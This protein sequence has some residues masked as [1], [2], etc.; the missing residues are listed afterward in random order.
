MLLDCSQILGRSMKLGANNGFCEIG[1]Q[2]MQ[3]TGKPIIGEG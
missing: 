2:A 3:P 1:N